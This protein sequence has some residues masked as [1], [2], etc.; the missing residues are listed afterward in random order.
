LQFTYYTEKTVSQCML[1]MN[2]RLHGSNRIQGWVDKGGSF[3]LSVTSPVMRWFRRTTR[4]QAK[5]ERQ[6]S[7]T[8][9]KGYVS[10]GVG[11][12][13]R[14]IIFGAMGLLAILLVAAGA[15]LPALIVVAAAAFLNIPLTG[16]YNNSDVLLSEVQRTLKAK[17]T[18]PVVVK[19]VMVTKKPTP[20]KKTSTAKKPTAAKSSAKAKS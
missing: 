4:L 19:K 1:A 5:A 14:L 3:S 2:E 15:L 13:E 6:G 20:A 9:V 11:P 18:P 8:I 10:D 16:D 7:V 17:H 12:R